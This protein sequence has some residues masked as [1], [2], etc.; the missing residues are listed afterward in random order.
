MPPVE[1]EYGPEPSRAAKKGRGLL[2]RPARFPV[3]RTVK[4]VFVPGTGA[5]RVSL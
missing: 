4:L 1:A 3:G 5:A 2:R